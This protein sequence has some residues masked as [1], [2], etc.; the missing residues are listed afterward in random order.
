MAKNTTPTPTL[1]AGW[2]KDAAQMLRV[3]A[4]QGQATRGGG[5]GRQVSF[6]CSICIRSP[7]T[8]PVAL[9][10]HGARVIVTMNCDWEWNWD[11]DCESVS[12]SVNETGRLTLS[13]HSGVVKE[14]SY[15]NY[16]LASLATLLTLLHPFCLF[17]LPTPLHCLVP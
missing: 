2:A 13:Q 16:F 7:G 15:S 5:G 9:I 3:L 12:G 6:N 11:C 1:T 4:R 17:E 8:N 10:V 14:G